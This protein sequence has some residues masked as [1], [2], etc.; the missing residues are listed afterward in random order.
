MPFLSIV[1]FAELE[2]ADD[3][4][5]HQTSCCRQPCTLLQV[6][7]KESATVTE[8]ETTVY[9]IKIW[10]LH[11]FMGLADVDETNIEN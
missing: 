8:P 1:D 11:L 4:G 6:M 5:T 7:K 2:M 10:G 9:M 3:L